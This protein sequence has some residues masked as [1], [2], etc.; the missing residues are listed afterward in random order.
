[1]LKLVANAD[2]SVLITFQG[3]AIVDGFHSV[4]NWVLFDGLKPGFI[5]ASDS[6]FT[7][8]CYDQT[9][10]QVIGSLTLLASQTAAA[11]NPTVINACE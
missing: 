11:N 6:M 1:M 2:P 9:V 7:G 8:F 3:L 10:A 5:L 4:P